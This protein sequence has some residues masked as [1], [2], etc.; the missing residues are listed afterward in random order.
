M[1]GREIEGEE[2]VW[3]TVSYTVNL[4]N[5]ESARVEMGTSENVGTREPSEVR[6]QLCEKLIVEVS[7]LGEEMRNATQKRFSRRKKHED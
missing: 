4:G 7:E 5:Y 2:K 1:S 6:T 3:V